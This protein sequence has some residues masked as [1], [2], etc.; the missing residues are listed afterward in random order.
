MKLAKHALGPHNALH[1]LKATTYKMVNVIRVGLNGNTVQ[2]VISR[3]V[4]SVKMNFTLTNS[5]VGVVRVCKDVYRAVVAYMA[6]SSVYRD[7]SN[8]G[9]CVSNVTRLC[10]G[11]LIAQV[12]LNVIPV[13][14]QSFFSS[15]AVTMDVN[16]MLVRTPT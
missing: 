11:A 5:S 2:S 4:Y 10:L 15:P 7:I 6:V 13:G 12:A 8:K 14:S 16:A 9:P 3:N 1:A